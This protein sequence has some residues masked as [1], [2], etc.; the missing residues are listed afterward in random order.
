VNFFVTAQ[1]VFGSDDNACAPDYAAGGAAGFGVDGDYI[2][3]GALGGLC[4]GIGKFD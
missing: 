2:C 4:Q 1:S 3:R